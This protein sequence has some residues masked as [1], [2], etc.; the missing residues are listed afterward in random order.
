M[1]KIRLG[2]RNDEYNEFDI[3]FIKKTADINYFKREAPKPN[4]IGKCLGSDDIYLSLSMPVWDYNFLILNH[5][6]S[7]EMDLVFDS[8][9]G[10]TLKLNSKCNTFRVII[11][12]SIFNI[13]QLYVLNKFLVLDGIKKCKDKSSLGL[14][15]KVLHSMIT[16]DDMLYLEL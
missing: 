4:E 9:H 2:R 15:F 1:D 6:E 5:E 3:L 8:N 12:T 10:L 7:Q 16:D 14:I 13:K 11:K